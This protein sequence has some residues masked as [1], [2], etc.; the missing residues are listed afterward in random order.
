MIMPF[1]NRRASSFPQAIPISA[2]FASPGPLTAQ[3]IIATCSFIFGKPW[4]NSSISF[5]SGIKS[6][7]VLPQV[8]QEVIVI[9]SYIPIEESSSFAAKTSLTGS[10]V[11][12]ILIVSP[13][14]SSN[15]LPSPTPDLIKPQNV[16]PASVTPMCSG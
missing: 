6:V 13:I 1:L 8:G 4:M 15:N 11:R 14:P 7:C 12:D 10:S 2:S 3:P 9:L 16:V 5:T